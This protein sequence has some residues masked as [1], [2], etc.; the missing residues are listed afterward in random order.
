MTS[1]TLAPETT[2]VEIVTSRSLNA[3]DRCDRCGAAAYIGAWKFIGEDFHELLFCGH[4]GKKHMDAL[5]SQG[6]EINDQTA[7]LFEN[8]KPMSG[9]NMAD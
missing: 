9:S 2:Q 7:R 8:T 6:F 3:R 4:H 5:K 1:T